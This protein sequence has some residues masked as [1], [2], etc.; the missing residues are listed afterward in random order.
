M[1]PILAGIERIS[2]RGQAAHL[3]G[4]EGE[5]EVAMQTQ[6][7]MIPINPVIPVMLGQ[8][9]LWMGLVL[10]VG[11]WAAFVIILPRAGAAGP[12]GW[13]PTLPLVPPTIGLGLGALGWL[14]S[15]WCGQRLGGVAGA[16]L[17][18]NTL[19]L[20]LALALAFLHGGPIS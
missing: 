19:L 18:L 11:W 3:G 20:I 7:T 2:L 4:T 16:G 17:I 10:S 14:T 5:Q 9:S 8:A 1:W 13:Q 15:Q 12:G 6:K